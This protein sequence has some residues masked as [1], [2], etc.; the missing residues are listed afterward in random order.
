MYCTFRNTQD[1]AD[2]KNKT[3]IIDKILQY[4]F[5]Y[6]KFRCISIVSRLCCIFWV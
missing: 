1:V 2:L 4:L 6:D 3:A 5:W